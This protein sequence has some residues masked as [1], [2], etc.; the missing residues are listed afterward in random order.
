MYK[1]TSDKQKDR[2]QKTDTKALSALN[3]MDGIYTAELH[4]AVHTESLNSK[5]L[6]WEMP[7][8]ETRCFLPGNHQADPEVHIS[9]PFPTG[10]SAWT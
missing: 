4:T 1:E 3:N 8:I 5:A 2:L 7:W 10:L 6:M 9:V